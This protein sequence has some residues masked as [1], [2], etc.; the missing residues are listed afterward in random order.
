M[1]LFAE[2]HN[3]DWLISVTVLWHS[4][5][6]YWLISV[7]GVFCYT[8]AVFL[9]DFS[10]WCV[11]LHSR[12]VFGWFQSLVCFVTQLLCLLADFSHWCVL[13]HSHCVYWPIS[14]TGV[15]VVVVVVFFAPQFQCLL[16]D[17][18]NLLVTESQCS[19]VLRLPDGHSR[20]VC[21]SLSQGCQSLWNE[22]H[23]GWP[24][25]VW[26]GKTKSTSVLRKGCVSTCSGAPSVFHFL[27]CLLVPHGKFG[28][29]QLMQEQ[30]YPFLL[31]C[32]VFSCVQTIV[33]LPAFWIFNEHTH[34]EACNCV[35]GLYGHHK[36]VF[37]L[38]VD[39]ER[40]IA[41]HTGDSNLHR[42]CTLAFQSAA[43]PT[44]LFPLPHRL[45][46]WGVEWVCCRAKV[47][48]WGID[49]VF[50]HPSAKILKFTKML[51]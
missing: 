46:Y 11:L 21:H 31:V 35:L 2:N 29:A 28:S 16:V 43:F 38:K 8:V 23:G 1:F 41:C 49:R 25:G 13:L 37:T 19:G 36:R 39:S 9:A 15:F 20:R 24:R 18:S 48:M 45:K 22:G 7:T 30:H 42:Y 14:V 10:H 44:D 51:V 27:K 34:V 40:K 50:Q 6:V 4:R 17:L 47:Q 3:V 33:W 32:V 26:N 12:C 5:C